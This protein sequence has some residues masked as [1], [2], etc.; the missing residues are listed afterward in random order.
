M[1]LTLKAGGHKI[2][3]GKID[4]LYQHSLSHAVISLNFSCSNFSFANPS[5]IN[6]T[7][8]IDLPI[9]RGC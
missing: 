4:A 1:V 6:V 7:A 2:P 3:N 9:E 8:H 5:L